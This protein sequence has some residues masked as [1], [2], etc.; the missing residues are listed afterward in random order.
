MRPAASQG[1][2]SVSSEVVPG[3]SAGEAL[4]FAGGS[5]VG[6]AVFGV[7]PGDGEADE[8]AG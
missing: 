2:R 3:A 7:E 5:V 4:L 8:S 6:A 1:L